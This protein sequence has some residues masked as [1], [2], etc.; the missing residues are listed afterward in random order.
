MLIVLPP[1]ETKTPG[2]AGSALDLGRLAFPELTPQRDRLIDALEKLA[3][4][5]P[6]ARAALQVSAKKDAE[7]A[8]N[9]A[10]RSAATVPAI[11]R[12]TGVLFDALDFASL[13][14]DRQHRAKE[15][16]YISSA[17]FGV[18]RACD[19]IPA[20]RLSA[21]SRL[22]DQPR[23]AALW[24][25]PLAAALAHWQQP[26]LDLRS[27]AYAAFTPIPH[28]ITARVVTEQPDGTRK[29][30][31][32]FNKATKGR[33]ARAVAASKRAAETIS[34]VIASARRAGL[35]AEQTGDRALEIVT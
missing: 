35:R 22:P 7:I 15:R 25:E 17:L 10:L 28:A 20:Y 13:S 11:Q 8:A 9:A 32:H 27:G 19:Q 33:L 16:L 24:R 29:V 30:V 14:T 23:I 21:G 18:V 3:T 5:L 6:A 31:S 12:Y 34:D 1:S 26:V 2:G 4:D